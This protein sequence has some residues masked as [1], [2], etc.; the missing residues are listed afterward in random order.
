MDKIKNLFSRKFLLAL[1][2]VV[3]SLG[4]AYS[5]DTDATVKLICIIVA[6]V[7]TIVYNVV[8]GA[9]DAKALVTITAATLNKI[10][11]VLDELQ[12]DTQDVIE[13]DTLKAI[14]A[15]QKTTTGGE[16]DE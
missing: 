14:E 5:A 6:A 16:C 15:V 10:S 7:A 2:T 3:I 4:T 1:L 9:I 12:D 8:E 11:D 13:T